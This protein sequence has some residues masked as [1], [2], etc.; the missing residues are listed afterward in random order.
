[1][2]RLSEHDIEII[3]RTRLFRQVSRAT[4]ETLMGAGNIKLLPKGQTLFRQGDE[5]RHFY[6]VL[7]GWMKIFRDTPQGEQAVLGV[8]GPGETFAEAA[9]FIAGRYPANAEAVEA[10]RLGVVSQDALRAEI[11]RDPSLA[12]D[13]LGSLARHLHGMIDDMEQLKTRNAEQRLGM[14]LF[15]MC[16]GTDTPTTV[17]LPYEK[18]LIA[19][20]LGMKP[21]SLSRS[22]SRLGA[23]GVRTEGNI[24]TIEDP[25]RLSAHCQ[26]EPMRRKSD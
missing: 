22:F 19:A 8:F 23:A 12:F 11:G 14:F 1:M 13:M 21:E 3:G 20:R 26:Q 5:A 2:S 25:L 10:A 15:A 24:V 4:V 9:A 18:S 6:V 7:D 16:G 17:R